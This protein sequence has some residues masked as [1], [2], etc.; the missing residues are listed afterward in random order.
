MNT[1]KI[2]FK[3]NSKIMTTKKQVL[4]KWFKGEVYTEGGSVKNPFSGVEVQLTATELSMYDFIIG[5]NEM[6]QRVGFLTPKS[7]VRDFNRGRMWFAKNNSSAY[8][9]LID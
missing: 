7:V 2:I 4:P 3:N 5:A 9:K 1:V 8:L 6:I